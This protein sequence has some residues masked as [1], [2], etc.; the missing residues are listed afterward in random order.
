[1]RD[2]EEGSRAMPL[3]TVT[4]LIDR[5]WRRVRSAPTQR[6]AEPSPTPPAPETKLLPVEILVDN[7]HAV[8]SAL[9]AEGIASWLISD[10]T[11]IRSIVGIMAS[12]RA[13][14]GRSLGRLADRGYWVRLPDK[15][16]PEAPLSTFDHSE[17]VKLSTVFVLFK[18]Y[19]VAGSDLLIRGDYSCEV[20][21]WESETVNGAEY[22]MAP[23]ENRA[24]RQLAAEGFD[25]ATTTWHGVEALTPRVLL[26]RMI[27]D[28]TFPIDVV[29][30]WVDGSDPRWR[31]KRARAEAEATGLEFHPEATIASRF[32]DHEELRYSL[33][34]LEYFAPWVR[35]IYLVTDDQVP[36]WMDTTNPK[37]QVVDHRDIFTNPANLPTFNSNAIIS[38]LH[39]IEGLSEH[40]IFMNDDVFLGRWVT[41]DRFFTPSGLAK[42]F[43]S[44][45]RRPFAPA[46]VEDEP[47]LNLTRNIRQLLRERFGITVSRAIKH[48][49]HPQLRSV[50]YEIEDAFR[51]RYEQTSSHPFRHHD[52]IA[53][54]QLFHYY[55]Q[56]TG[57]AVAGSSRYEYI[58]TKDS[59]DRGQLHDLN[60][61]H[62]RDFFCLND[63]PLL[64]VDPMTDEEI[65]KFLTAYFPLPSSFEKG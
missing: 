58:N 63:T 62:N 27:D 5:F 12:D 65:T 29:Y 18:R 38:S 19:T 25:L 41:P 16:R 64:D 32:A 45:N 59:G 7:F 30:T 60:K 4:D 43:A 21:L 24:A 55:G 42:A 28:V 52:D 8:T 57:Q 2:D 26:D 48:T 53:A 9:T 1:M 56:I 22:L 39:H 20:E 40:Y 36:A 51:A 35:K 13:A 46:R 54:D 23:R 17:L 11:S 37:I 31:E 61:K 14:F 44:Y 3:T 10:E 6:H 49:P 33:R 47:H 34:S 15:T 50:Q